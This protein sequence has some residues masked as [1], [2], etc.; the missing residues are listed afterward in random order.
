MHIT[1]HERVEGHP[2]RW[3]VFLHG[4]DEPIHVELS[5][6]HRAHLDMTDDQIHEALPHA[7]ERQA[8]ANRDDELSS[9]VAWDQ[10]PPGRPH[11]PAGLTALVSGPADGA[12]SGAWV[13]GRRR[14]P[15]A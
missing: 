6:E 15:S 14:R 2:H 1:H 10:P 13:S 5:P 12:P 11:A 4:Q 7:I 3:H 9:Y 8:T